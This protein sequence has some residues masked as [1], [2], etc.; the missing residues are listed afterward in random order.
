MFLFYFFLDN[1]TGL[2]HINIQISSIA[3]LINRKNYCWTKSGFLMRPR[4]RVGFGLTSSG[5]GCTNSAR[6][7]LWFKCIYSFLYWVLM[8]GI[9]N[10]TMLVS[11]AFIYWCFFVAYLGVSDFCCKL[12][13]LNDDDFS[14]DNGFNYEQWLNQRGRRGL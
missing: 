4:F 8:I 13:K 5:S 1:K 12:I 2:Q 14:H 10:S 7:H 3:Y 6:F 11:Y 9:L